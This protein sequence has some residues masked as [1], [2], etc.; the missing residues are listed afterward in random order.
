MKWDGIK[1]VKLTGVRWEHP[2][3][4]YQPRLSQ[5][6]HHI[7]LTKIPHFIFNK[8]TA[9]LLSL[10]NPWILCLFNSAA[11]ALFS[12]KFMKIDLHG[13]LPLCQLFFLLPAL[14]AFDILTLAILHLGLNSSRVLSILSAIGTIAL[15]LL[16]S[17]FASLY[18]EGNTEL[19]WSRSV[20]VLISVPRYGM[21]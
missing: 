3:K 4:E 14:F 9:Y 19:N 12:H 20:E 7:H 8:L 5:F 1:L 6:R 13:P 17:V 2:F 18:L 11:V 21:L 16:S 10:E 15:V